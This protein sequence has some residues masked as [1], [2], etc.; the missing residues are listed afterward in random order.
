MKALAD[1]D[2]LLG[3]GLAAIR[4]QYAIP[5][6]FPP[7]V[8]AEAE[9]TKARALTDHADWTAREFV[10]LDPATSTDLDQAFIIEP[11]GGD[12]ILH[13]ALADIGWFVP[14][15][16]ALEAEA[17][18]RG[19]TLY[20]PDDRARLYPP[21]LSEAAASLLP[22]GPRPA[23]VASVRCASDGAVKLDSVTRAVIRSRAK[24]AYET[25]EIAAVPHLA[26]FAGRMKRSEDARGAAR[27]DP[28]E[29]EVERAADG[30]YHLTF[31]PWLPSETANASLS[32]AAN[33]AIA[34]AL[35]AA[36]TGLFREMAPPDER[37]LAR[38]RNTARAL[39]L[40][41]PDNATLLQF[42]RTVDPRTRPGA[43]FQLAV[44]RAGGG[45][46]YLPFEEGH[47][48]WHAALGATY[49]HATA[50]MRRLADRYVLEAALAIANGRPLPAACA[51]AFAR[52]PKVMDKA[53]AR[54]GA[55]ERAVIDLAETAL[56]HGHEG[57]TFRAVVTD[58]DERGARIQLCDRPVVSRVDAH[59]VASGDDLRVRLVEADPVKRILRF[60]R[61]N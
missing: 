59:R 9:R 31:R 18:Q 11:A 20:L 51:D 52:L 40:V 14:D 48:P 6:D 45:A 23:I 37:A 12:L 28:P 61:V 35:F 32:L 7:E 50:P 55:V 43:A 30:T 17:W 15:G 34:D 21:A 4:L 26:E 1:P 29:Q 27:V 56:L 53:D 19:L 42:E 57:E 58:L 36:K 41:W 60:E 25:V 13:Y 16:G 54:E 10:T 38:L 46:R 47:V 24:L 2:R 22:D 3:E 49:T 8:L 44:R 39:G 5:A 33:M